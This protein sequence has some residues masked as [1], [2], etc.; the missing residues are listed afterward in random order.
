M[1]KNGSNDNG[2]ELILS[3]LKSSLKALEE[4]LG[5]FDSTIEN[6]DASNAICWSIES[7]LL[8]GLKNVKQNKDFWDIIKRCSHKSTLEAIKGF[9]QIRSDVGRC[10]SWL[11]LSMNECCLESH[12]SV[13]TA[14][15]SLIVRYYLPSAFLLDA[16]AMESAM[17][18]IQDLSNHNFKLSCN[19]TV[20]NQWNQPPLQLAGI[21]SAKNLKWPQAKKKL[22][23]GVGFGLSASRSPLGSSSTSNSQIS[24]LPQFPKTVSNGHLGKGASQSAE[25]LSLQFTETGQRKSLSNTSSIDKDALSFTSSVSHPD[26]GDARQEFYRTVYDISESEEDENTKAFAPKTSEEQELRFQYIVKHNLD[27]FP[28]NYDKLIT[29][30]HEAEDRQNLHIVQGNLKEDLP[31]VTITRPSD[32]HHVNCQRVDG[33]LN[34]DDEGEPPKV[35]DVVNPSAQDLAFDAVE[36]NDTEQC[37]ATDSLI[38][39]L[40]GDGE[41]ITVD[42]IIEAVMGKKSQDVK[43]DEEKKKDLIKNKR[44]CLHEASRKDID[45]VKEYTS[46]KQ[47]KGLSSQCFQCKSCSAP[48]G[49]FFGKERVCSFDKC[50][51]CP[52]CLEKD[53]YVLPCKV[54]Y[55]WDFRPYKVSKKN[56]EF[57]TSCKATP[58]INIDDLNPSLYDHVPAL[59]NVKL[60]RLKL[61]HL[62]V[63]LLS[64]NLDHVISL[65][66]I[67]GDVSYYTENIHIYSMEDLVKV[68]S[69]HLARTLEKACQFG[70]SHVHSCHLCSQKGFY[71][72][73]CRAGGVIYPFDLENTVRCDSCK[74]VYHKTCK[75]SS[76]ACPKC[77]RRAMKNSSSSEPNSLELE[78]STYNPQNSINY[79]YTTAVR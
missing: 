2:K 51:Y 13:I 25:S 72:E 78:K 75:T 40:S 49:M 54:V 65:H 70:I 35:S 5:D 77:Q 57:L 39:S 63:Y 12:M 20:L 6:T 21:V 76:R 48:I 37:N 7:M 26:F 50:Y 31:V 79:T 16:K 23:T 4:E 67:L 9:S 42:K 61:K 18:L 34:D 52:Q 10:R 55:N 73:I 32:L 58:L 62:K 71:C 38:K 69:G 30:S 11:R 64:C 74:A 60:T 17:D 28:L 3:Y 56:H 27:K 46:I 59:N 53:E 29:A 36:E 45:I 68:P 24:H 22:G 1:E 66:S 8:H 19:S 43:E 41:M 44:H 15:S 14:E 47:E 33:L